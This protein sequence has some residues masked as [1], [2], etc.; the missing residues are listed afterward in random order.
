VAKA[1]VPVQV[2][3][4]AARFRPNDIPLLVG[5]PARIRAEIGWTPA[6]PLE[7]TLD[8]MLEYWRGQMR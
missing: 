6:I 1:R 4:D 3:V 8:D 5:N 2:R 7:Q